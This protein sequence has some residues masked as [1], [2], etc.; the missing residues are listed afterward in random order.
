MALTRVDRVESPEGVVWRKSYTE[1]SRGARIAALRAVARTLGLAPLVAPLPQTAEQACATEQRMIRRLA[2]LGAHVPAIVA[3]GPRELVLSDLG[4]T[5]AG[6]CR[7]E[8]DPQA[9]RAL[10]AAGLD[11]LASLHA[12]G[13]HLSQAFARNMTLRD[14]VVGFID[15]EEDPATTMPPAAAQARDLIF[16]AHST[17]RF[18]VDVPGAHA[19]LLARFLQQAPA[20]VRMHVRRTARRLA[21]LAPVARPFGARSR[22]VADALCSLRDAG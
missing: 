14:G 15:L 19:Q 16:Y 10:V 17:A 3:S 18:L 12:A 6:T 21:W 13:G 9:R 5:L 1:G 22:A 20:D 11:A 2:A 7:R 8:P 4:P